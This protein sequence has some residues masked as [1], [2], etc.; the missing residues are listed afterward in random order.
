LVGLIAL[1]SLVVRPAP[2]DLPVQAHSETDG[3]CDW[4]CNSHLSDLPEMPREKSA[5]SAA[6]A[7][8]KQIMDPV[9]AQ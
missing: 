3:N 5:R 1:L 4:H 9:F 7:K 8:A 6:I 2:V